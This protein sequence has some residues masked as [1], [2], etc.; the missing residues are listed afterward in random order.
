MTFQLNIKASYTFAYIFP[1]ERNFNKNK[2]HEFNVNDEKKAKKYINKT[3]N[4]LS[5]K[6]EGLFW[7]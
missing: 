7:P 5:C 6:I 2:Y 4:H 1:V 3:N